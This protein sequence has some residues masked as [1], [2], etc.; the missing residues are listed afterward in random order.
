VFVLGFIVCWGIISSG[1]RGGEP[2]KT[3]STT[4]AP[5]SAK[6]PAISVPIY[7][8]TV[9]CCC[10]TNGHAYDCG[11]YTMSGLL[12]V[13]KAA[14]LPETLKFVTMPAAGEGMMKQE[15][16]KALTIRSITLVREKEPMH[17]GRMEKE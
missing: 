9:T 16:S 14:V 6:A 3:Q 2:T 13:E 15:K 10:D 1:F 5:E 12:P 8:A 11:K 17:K 4:A 7:S